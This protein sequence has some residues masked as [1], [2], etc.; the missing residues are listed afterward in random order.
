VDLTTVLFTNLYLFSSGISLDDDASN[1]ALDESLAAFTAV[2]EVAVPSYL[3]LQMMIGQNGQPVTLTRITPHRTMATSVRVPLTALGPRFDPGSRVTLYAADA[4]AFV[5]LAADLSYALHLPT[6]TNRSTDVGSSDG[7]DQRR[8]QVGSDRRITLDADMPPSP[9]ASGL[10]E[11]FGLSELSTIN[12]AVGVLIGHGHHPDHAA[13]T[14]R[15]DASRDGL[16]P[17]IYAARLLERGRADRDTNPRRQVVTPSGNVGD[18][19]HRP[20][21]LPWRRVR[22]ISTRIPLYSSRPSRGRRGAKQPV[23]GT[24]KR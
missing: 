12:R 16:E 10:Y 24:E 23:P 15:R 14:L 8:G 7:D 20:S 17:H 4:G 2:V 13:D 9:P 1:D 18:A 6:C 11:L 21:A 3:G 19:E 22:R 5:D